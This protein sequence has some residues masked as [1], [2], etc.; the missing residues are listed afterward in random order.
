MKLTEETLKMA[1]I[2]GLDYAESTDYMTNALRSFKMEMQDA[3]R[4]VD[5]Y[6]AIAAK[7]ATDVEEL[8]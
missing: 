3:G 5:V 6:S 8:A 2:S 7:T 1:R 4:I